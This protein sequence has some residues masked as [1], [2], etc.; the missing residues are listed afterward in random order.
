MDPGSPG[1]PPI[2]SGAGSNVRR[3]GSRVNAECAQAGRQCAGV[4][5]AASVSSP[6]DG[7]RSGGGRHVAIHTAAR[8]RLGSGF[9][10][11]TAWNAGLL[12]DQVCLVPNSRP[13]HTVIG[14][15]ARD[16]EPTFGRG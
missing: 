12:A 8:Q 7:E 16:A 10:Q 1:P 13:S 9:W 3:D 5:T 6:L 14:T 15:A 2:G 11:I 4:P